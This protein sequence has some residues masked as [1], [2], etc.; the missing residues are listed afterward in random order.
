MHRGNYVELDRPTRITFDFSVL[1]MGEETRVEIRIE[2]RGPNACELTLT[3]DLGDGD[4]AREMQEAAR[5][6]W[7]SMLAHMERTLFPKR[8]AV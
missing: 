4:G 8:V 1:N 6:G 5:K 7:T 3:H 2:P